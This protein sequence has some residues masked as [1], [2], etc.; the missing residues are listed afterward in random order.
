MVPTSR[1]GEVVVEEGVGV[2]REEGRM[3]RL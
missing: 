2:G 1:A 3:R